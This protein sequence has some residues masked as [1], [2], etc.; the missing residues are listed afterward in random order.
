[1]PRVVRESAR[2]QLYIGIPRVLQWT[3]KLMYFEMV[4]T[5]AIW[6]K[7]LLYTAER[8][9]LSNSGIRALDISLAEKMI[10]CSDGIAADFHF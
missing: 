4:L 7:L 5:S 8:K 2:E 10:S 3:P 1:M 9:S 6:F